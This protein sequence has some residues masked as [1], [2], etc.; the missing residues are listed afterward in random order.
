LNEAANGLINAL[1]YCSASEITNCDV[2]DA[3]IGYYISSLGNDYVISCG[4][5]GCKLENVEYTTC[6]CKYYFI[7]N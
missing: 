4:S 2:V 7:V 1:V 6:G 5:T 3:T